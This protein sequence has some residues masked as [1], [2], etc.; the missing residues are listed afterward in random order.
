METIKQAA[1]LLIPPEIQ[2]LRFALDSH[3]TLKDALAY[4]QHYRPRFNFKDWLNGT[5]AYN[6]PME[7]DLDLGKLVKSS[8]HSAQSNLAEAFWQKGDNNT[9]LD[10]MTQSPAD[11]A[12]ENLDNADQEPSWRRP[13]GVPEEQGIELGEMYT[14][15]NDGIVSND[16]DTQIAALEADMPYIDDALGVGGYRFD[17]EGYAELKQKLAEISIPKEQLTKQEYLGIYRR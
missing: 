6:Q 3:H 5:G 17:P 7:G 8:I 10:I 11:F 4:A 9:A 13:K 14:N 2:A 12:G 1:S 15:Q 16:L